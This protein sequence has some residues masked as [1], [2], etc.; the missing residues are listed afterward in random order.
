MRL[1]AVHPV[2]EECV[3]DKLQVARG[4]YA[5]PPAGSTLR[6]YMVAVDIASARTANEPGTVGGSPVGGTGGGDFIASEQELNY[7]SVPALDIPAQH[8]PFS[9]LLP[10]GATTDSFITA[11]LLPPAVLAVLDA[12]FASSAEP[13]TVNA[14]LKLHGKTRTGSTVETNEVNLAVVVTAAT[15]ATGIPAQASG[16]CGVNGYNSTALTCEAAPAGP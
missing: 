6:G 3:P 8:L 5:L 15:C 10:E 13:V 1:L 16:A 12:H 14:A 7:S 9:Y 2:D 4:I 11:D